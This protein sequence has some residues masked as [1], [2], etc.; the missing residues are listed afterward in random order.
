MLSDL[1]GNLIDR[2][3]WQAGVPGGVS[4]VRD[5]ANTTVYTAYPSFEAANSESTFTTLEMTVMDQSDPVHINEV[6]KYNT[7]SAID[8]DGDRG[9]WV[10]LKNFS[11]EAVTLLGYFLSDDADDLYKWAL[12]D[13]TLQSGECKIVFLSGKDRTSGELHANFGLADEETEVFF[14]SLNGMRTE[15]MSL[16]GI[17]RDNISI[18]L[19][20]DRNLRYYATPTPGTDNAHGFETADQIGCFDNTGVFIS[21]VRAA[22]DDLQSGENDWI[23]LHNGSEQAID[24][25]GWTITDGQ[26]AETVYMFSGQSIEGED[27]PY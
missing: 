20:K 6:L 15:S 14:T 19:D 24:L 26:N 5:A 13:V 4:I 7:L 18:G 12:P 17:T 21:E 11:G 22:S 27:I 25:T 16:A 3:S 9:E 10:E 1:Q 2:M 8:A 23:E